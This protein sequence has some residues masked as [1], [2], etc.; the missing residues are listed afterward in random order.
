MVDTQRGSI[1]RVPTLCGLPNRKAQTDQSLR[2]T[3]D[4]SYSNNFDQAYLSLQAAVIQ[5]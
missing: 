5:T 1:V 4:W 3:L 2:T